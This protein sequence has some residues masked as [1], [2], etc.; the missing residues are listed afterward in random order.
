MAVTPL[1][2]TPGRLHTIGNAIWRRESHEWLKKYAKS[3]SSRKY[4]WTDTPENDNVTGD[5]T[6]GN[7]TIVNFA[8]VASEKEKRAVE[9]LDKNLARKK[10]GRS[11]C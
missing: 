8:A 10:R 2:G 1:D 11:R 4:H 6:A 5:K 7:K 3:L 9:E